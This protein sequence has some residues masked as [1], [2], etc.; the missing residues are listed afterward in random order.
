MA[1]KTWVWV[2]VALVGVAV[3]GLIALVGAGAYFVAREIDTKPASKLSAE[4]E[5]RKE[6]E[7]FGD[8]KP[9]IEIDESGHSVS[10]NF[11]PTAPASATKPDVMIVMAWDPQDER[12]VRVRLPFWLLR[13]GSRG[14]GG[15]MRLGSSES[16]ITFEQLKITVHDL[17]RLGPALIVSHQSPRGER[18]LIWTQ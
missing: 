15:S 16:R 13:L 2:V 17:E 12:I 8:Q 10:S 6:L 1:V 3:L 5:F 7:R 14:E 4:Q 18:V 11:D 9:L